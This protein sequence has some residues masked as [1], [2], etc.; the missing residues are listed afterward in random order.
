MALLQRMGY[1]DLG[2]WWEKPSGQHLYV[3][4]LH[5]RIKVSVTSPR[6]WG[7]SSALQASLDSRT[8]ALEA[9]SY[10]ADTFP[11]LGAVLAR[12]IQLEWTRP[13][14][15]MRYAPYNYP[16]LELGVADAAGAQRDAALA[17]GSLLQ[18]ES[19][20]ARLEQALETLDSFMVRLGSGTI[21]PVVVVDPESMERP[22]WDSS[23]ASANDVDDQY[24][25]VLQQTAVD[26]PGGVSWTDLPAALRDDGWTDVLSTDD[27]IA[28]VHP[29]GG[30]ITAYD[31]PE[32]VVVGLRTPMWWG[33]DEE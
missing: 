5:G 4:D 18:L 11:E 3:D 15:V 25:F 23:A 19:Q 9:E 2:H 24:F 10:P 26:I 22:S 1:E 8:V 33:S 7:D 31:S 6:W 21:P 14:L 29:D 12:V 30:I 16:R 32:G 20:S 27:S 28:A 17:A 13:E